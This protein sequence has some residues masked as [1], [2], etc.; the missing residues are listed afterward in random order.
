V[1]SNKVFLSQI[2]SLAFLQY[3]YV[4]LVLTNDLLDERHG[5]SVSW[6]FIK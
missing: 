4:S 5:Q 6:N 1:K 3:L 2:P